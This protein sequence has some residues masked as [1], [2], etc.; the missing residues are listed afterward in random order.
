VLE[1]APCQ[2]AN[3]NRTFSDPRSAIFAVAVATI[4]LIA[5]I[6]HSG[7]IAGGYG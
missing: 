2:P 3:A 5:G 1:A 7:A 6:N 4:A